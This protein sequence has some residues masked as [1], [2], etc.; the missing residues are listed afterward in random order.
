MN[1]QTQPMDTDIEVEHSL[2]TCSICYDDVTEDNL[3][4]DFCHLAESHANVCLSCMNMYVESKMNDAYMGSCPVMY[5]P[6]THRE[7]CKPIMKYPQWCHITSNEHGAKYLKLVDSVLAF[8]CGSCH[9][10]RSLNVPYSTVDHDKSL[11]TLENLLNNDKMNLLLSGLSEYIKGVHSTD[12]FYEQCVECF[13]EL[14]TV[15]ASDEAAWDIMN[16]ILNCTSEPERR[17]NLQLRYYRNRPKIWTSCCKKPHCYKCQISHYHD[18]QSCEEY[19]ISIGYRNDDIHL[20]CPQC[21]VMLTKGD[22][23]SSIT[24][25]CKYNFSWT[26]EKQLQESCNRFS[27]EFPENTS[28]ECAIYLCENKENSVLMKDAKAW[29]KKHSLEVSTYLVKWWEAQFPSCPAQC[30]SHYHQPRQCIVS[31]TS[32][33]LNKTINANNESINSA[34]ALYRKLHYKEV[35]H[36]DTERAIAL[37]NIFHVFNRNTDLAFFA[38]YTLHNYGLNTG[39]D[40]NISSKYDNALWLS[41]QN[42]VNAEFMNKFN[43][44]RAKVVIEHRSVFQFL[45]LYGSRSIVYNNLTAA[46]F[47]AAP[48]MIPSITESGSSEK[49]DETSQFPRPYAHC[50]NTADNQGRVITY[51]KP[52]LLSQA[53][54]YSSVT[55]WNTT[56]SNSNLKFSMDNTEVKRQG[57]VSCYPIAV[58]DVPGQF[59]MITVK[60]TEA[61]LT[62]NM[63]SFGIVRVVKDG[64]LKPVLDRNNSIG[65]MVD[66]YGIYDDRTPSCSSRSGNVSHEPPAPTPHNSSSIG[67]CIV[68]A[69]Q[70]NCYFR[71]LEQGDIIRGVLNTQD[72]W[73]D[74]YVNRCQQPEQ[75]LNSSAP[76][77]SVNAES[78]NP[79]PPSH[80][81]ALYHRFKIP[82]GVPSDYEF[83]VTMANDHCLQIIPPVIDAP[84]TPQA[85]FNQ[86]PMYHTEQN[87]VYI[88]PSAEHLLMLHNYKQVL[89]VI[90]NTPIN[91]IN[92]QDYYDVKGPTKHSTLEETS[93]MYRPRHNQLAL[94]ATD[95]RIQAALSLVENLSMEWEQ[96]CSIYCSLTE[97]NCLTSE[98][99]SNPSEGYFSPRGM[100][101]EELTMHT[102]RV[103]KSFLDKN[104][105]LEQYRDM[106]STTNDPSIICPAS[107]IPLPQRTLSS[108]LY[109][110]RNMLRAASYDRQR[111]SNAMMENAQEMAG[112]FYAQHNDGA[113]FV[114]ASICCTAPRLLHEYSDQAD[115]SGT[116]RGNRPPTQDEIDSAVA[117]MACY[118]YDMQEWYDSQAR[119]QDPIL[120]STDQIIRQCRCLPRHYSQ[121]TKSGSYPK[122]DGIFAM[123]ACEC[124]NA[125]SHS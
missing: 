57:F 3:A 63:L 4:K 78:T 71:K 22:G 87:G 91:I 38:V 99:K 8:L 92:N 90:V 40:T 85:E 89:S 60:L 74:I 81:P 29:E 7:K 119:S 46:P 70:H 28:K 83:A 118:P 27:L 52:F 69:A 95:S 53:I 76:K 30:A 84:S 54:A 102:M 68:E 77:E 79:L 16:T 112:W 48:S 105:A 58:A 39:S 117:F 94:D 19:Q 55:H 43:Y 113:M 73:F 64:K 107:Q 65:R 45:Y 17:A 12:A 88:S 31:G 13:P 124:P 33:Q 42:W 104:D 62:V 36:Y 44:N 100:I 56:K 26:K 75:F 82:E 18:G 11:G 114:A 37:Q 96:E 80:P 51:A 6:C 1:R 67:Y 103:V 111:K 106:E 116:L 123:A 59:S 115:E 108:H 2:F 110:F 66:S 47:L 109:T 86:A 72:G 9:C 121:T 10:L 25:V 15:V 20:P 122:E 35:T 14:N 97:S 32:K 125:S 21:G 49:S 5:C 50:T 120:Q 24:C 34:V 61:P 93:G 41:T 98:S 23:C 101:I